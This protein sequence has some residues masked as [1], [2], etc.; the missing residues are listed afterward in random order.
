MAPIAVEEVELSP[1]QS[2]LPDVSSDKEVDKNAW[3]SWMRPLPP[4]DKD[5]ERSGGTLNLTKCASRTMQAM[6]DLPALEPIPAR[7]LAGS[8]S[9][10]TR[11][12][13]QR[14]PWV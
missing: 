12:T 13:P 3:R 6:N 14:S 5:W 8:L 1:S 11:R 4:A 10:V 2:D 9:P 7:V